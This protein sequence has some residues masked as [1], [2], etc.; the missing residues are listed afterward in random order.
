MRHEDLGNGHLICE[1][2]GIVAPLGPLGVARSPSR[3]G[4]TSRILMRMLPHNR[5]PP[6]RTLSANRPPQPLSPHLRCP[7]CCA[8]N[9]R[10]LRLP[11]QLVNRSTGFCQDVRKPMNI[12]LQNG[13]QRAKHNYRK[14]TISEKISHE[15]SISQKRCGRMRYGVS[16]SCGG[17]WNPGWP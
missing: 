6:G 4:L 7:L 11:R 17:I 9:S 3:R 5:S 14:H 12:A 8:A 15:A 1:V 16:T 10:Q 13:P 2:T